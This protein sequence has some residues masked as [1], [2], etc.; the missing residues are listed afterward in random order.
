MHFLLR[1]L[2]SGIFCV[3][4]LFTIWMVLNVFFV[5]KIHAQ[6]FTETFGTTPD[7]TYTATTYNNYDT[8]YPKSGN[9]IISNN[10]TPASPAGGACIRLDFLPNTSA[11]P[12]FILFQNIDNRTGDGNISWWWFKGNAQSNGSGLDIEWST[13]NGATYTRIALGTNPLGNDVGW[14]YLTR[15]GI[16]AVNNLWLRISNTSGLS[17][18]Y[19]ML[20]NISLG[21]TLACPPSQLPIVGLSGR[22]DP[23]TVTL[24]A[25]GGVNY[26]WYTASTGGTP[27]ASGTIYTTPHLTN[28]TTYY[29]ASV[30]ADGCEAS[31]RR[32]AIAWVETYPSAPVVIDGSVCG[33]GKV[34][35]AA[36]GSPHNYRWYSASS[37]GSV[38]AEGSTF[39]TPSLSSTTTYY[40]SSVHGVCES[41]T[42]APVVAYVQ[43]NYT[44]PVETVGNGTAGTSIGSYTGWSSPFSMSGTGTINTS[45]TTW[46]TST[47]GST[48]I[49]MDPNHT[50]DGRVV[51]LAGNRTWELA[52][53]NTS[54]LS[55][56]QFYF[57]MRRTN[58]AVPV[59]ALTIEIYNNGTLA[60]V[61][62]PIELDFPGTTTHWLRYTTDAMDGQ[63]PS[64]SNLSIKFVNS[65]TSGVRYF[66]IDDFKI[67][68][69]P[70]AGPLATGASRPGPGSVSL[71]A[72]GASNYRWYSVPSAG[73][74]LATTANYTTPFLSSTTNYYVASATTGGCESERS[75]A[76]ATIGNGPIESPT[77]ADGHRCGTGTVT[78]TAT[79]SS[80][81]YRWY[82]ASSGGTL[83]ASTA[84]YTT[85]SI[86]STTTY[87]VCAVHNGSESPRVAV[88]ANVYATLAAPTEVSAGVC[89]GGTATLSASG[90]FGAY[91]W[92]DVAAGGTV[93]ATT[94]T[95][96]TPSLSAT[97]TYYVSSTLN[98]CESARTP[99][100]ATFR[101]G[102]LYPVE[103]AGTAAAT[104][105]TSYTGWTSGLTHSGTGNIVTTTVSSWQTNAAGATGAVAT[106]P[107][108]TISGR[109]VEITGGATGQTWQI[110][111]IN[112]TGFSNVRI[113]FNLRRNNNT[114]PLS[115]LKIDVLNN[116]N[117]IGSLTPTFVD[118][119]IASTS[120]IRYSATGIIPEG[121]NVGIR[122]TNLNTNG[123]RT[124][125]LDDFKITSSIPSAPSVNNAFRCGPGAV[126]LTASGAA[127]YRWYNVA[128]GGSSLSSAATY[129]T[130]SLSSTT[131]YFVT[132]ST[133]GGCEHVGPRV[134]AIASINSVPVISQIPAAGLLSN[135]SF[136]GNANDATGTNN[137]ILINGPATVADRFGNSGSAYSF[138]GT[139]Q[140]V[141]TNVTYNNPNNY[142]ISVWFRTTTNS[143]GKIIGFGS[144]PTGPS[145][146]WDRC[147]WMVNDGRVF[148]GVHHSGIV[149]SVNTTASYNDGNWH[150][151]TATLSTTTGIKFFIDGVY[152][153]GDATAVAGQNYTGYWRFGYDTQTWVP[154]PASAFFNGSLDD[155]L[156][157]DR[158]LAPAEVSVL[159]SSPNGAGS[160]SPVCTGGTLNLTSTTIT[161]A[162]Y[163]WTGPDGFTSSQQNPSISNMS[164]AKSGVYTVVVTKDGCS[165]T[166][167]TLVNGVVLSGGVVSADATVCSGL[168]SG[169][170]SLS[171]HTGT[172]IR[173][174]S[175]TDNFNT[176]ANISNTTTS[177]SYSNLTSTTQ[178][179][180]V[181][182]SGCYEASSAS[183]TITVNPSPGDPSQYGNGTWNIYGFHDLN[184]SNYAGYYTEPSLSFD[185]RNRWTNT[186]SPS[187][188]SGY[189]GCA[190]NADYFSVSAK[191]T[192]FTNGFYKIDIVGQEKE[193]E[194]FVNGNLVFS[195]VVGSVYYSNV[196]SGSL[197]SFSTIEIRW[198]DVN[199]AACYGSINVTPISSP[200][201]ISAGV[202]EAVQNICPGTTPA[203][204]TSGTVYSTI[205]DAFV[206]DGIYSDN[207]YGS[208]TRMEVKWTT[209]P[210]FTRYAYFTFDLL[211]QT[212]PVTSAILSFD[213]RVSSSPETL[214]LGLFDVDTNWTEGSITFNS[215]PAPGLR[216]DT[217]PIYYGSIYS[218]YYVDVS[219]HIAAKKAAGFNKISFFIGALNEITNVGFISTKENG[220][221]GPKLTVNGGY[222]PCYVTYQWQKSENCNG[223]WEN[224]S[225]A[226]A[227]SYSPAALSMTTCYRRIIADACSNTATS[228]SIQIN[229]SNPATPTG[230]GASR[231]G[232]GILTLSAS[233]S[234]GIYNWYDAATGGTLLSSD[235]N[236]TT[237]SISSTTTYYVAAVNGSCESPRTP[238][239]ATITNATV[240]GILSG[241]TTVCSGSN[242]GN[243][244]L[245]GH[246]GDVTVWESSVDNFATAGIAIPNTTTGYTYNNLTS[247][248]YYRAVVQ[249]A[250]CASEYSSVVTIA[251]NSIPNAPTTI[252][253]SRCGTGT[254]TLS[255]SGSSGTYNWYDVA[256][257]GSSLETAATFTT[258]SISA[259]TTYYVSKVES[260]C[261]G[262]RAEVIA[263]INEITGDPA[264]FGNNTW[265]VY[266]FNDLNY[267]DYRGYYTENSLSF[268]SRTRWAVAASPSSA[269]GYVGCDVNVDAFSVSAKRTGFSTGFYRVDI[270]GQQREGDLLINGQVISSNILSNTYF[271]NIW[272]GELTAA[273]TI[274]FRWKD[275]NSA[276]SFG[277]INIVPVSN[278]GS[279]YP[280]RIGANQ[281][282]CSGNASSVLLSGTV[283]STTDDAFVKGGVSANNNFGSDTRIWLKDQGPEDNWR[284]GYIMF[285]LSSISNP[286][287]SAILSIEARFTAP[288]SG[289]IGIYEVDT[290]WSENII[291]Y[292]SRPMPGVKVDSFPVFYGESYGTHYVDLTNYIEVKRLAGFKKLAFF[293]RNLQP[294]VEVVY[295]R[296][297]E[298]SDRGPKLFVN[299]AYSVCTINYQWQ[300]SV[301]CTGVW[302]NITGA[303]TAQ[304]NPGVLSDTVCY[305]RVVTDACG[306]SATSNTVQININNPIAP[307]TSGAP[308]CGSGS[309]TLTAGGSA[310]TYNWYNVSSGGSSL[311]NTSTYATPNIS[312]TTS[313]YVSKVEGG[314]EG[315]RSEVVATIN[316]IPNAPATTGN[317]RCGTGTVT[318]SASGSSGTYNWYDVAAG[319]SSLETAAAFTTPSISATTTYYVASVENGCEGARAE[320]VAAITNAT[321]GGTLS[322][323][324]TVCSGSNTGNITLAG[325]AGDV[326]GWESSLDNF[327][328]AGTAIANT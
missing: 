25:S 260:G 267:S 59:S 60:T 168:N 173:W 178:F 208:N 145:T 224:I 191:R 248:T 169:N 46:E 11:T 36:S 147:I 74:S 217:F 150:L 118:F 297:K 252:G 90:S 152:V 202:I 256:A 62:N 139:N 210:D 222:S 279:I 164:A 322:G 291:T 165:A 209:V 196:W 300:R 249:A 20:D 230:T 160:N 18:S 77:A 261:E 68:S 161:G 84:V 179:R 280:G 214:W 277:S 114:M 101:S 7:G 175:S 253:N 16:P 149:K 128:A 91:A 23:G 216:I 319:G 176:I 39:L 206:R 97:T 89:G 278:P 203:T 246:A 207:N 315:P 17:N 113:F 323:A 148:Y 31:S 309:V 225:G 30:N 154:A 229:V 105:I 104:T 37:G 328:T 258:P 158:E 49:P 79:G 3:T 308:R 238:V 282:I 132:A 43:P 293:L 283:L 324:T 143:G 28:T 136:N 243:I 110:S 314:C 231:C 273:S 144:Q 82:D 4:R 218:K 266:G 200:N 73:V 87:Y 21:G 167:Q 232:A 312:S 115:E 287:S 197:N 29:V 182:Q 171:G 51:E 236:Y 125:Q 122:F 119:D 123:A 189:S 131:T 106:D 271:Y 185:S 162:S 228:N 121:S 199:G 71:S 26:R 290:T 166:A 186:A 275:A 219:N 292:N 298:D 15:S 286:V 41:A 302:E 318:L 180:A 13:D 257:G 76:V 138:N 55:R 259:T 78:L 40:V 262:S 250:G 54:G 295:V 9:G 239:V 1:K 265:H 45:V 129:T 251:V 194:L 211:S 50:V 22:C 269:T 70:P 52:N 263:V 83:L 98:G 299:S 296:S 170:L 88:V 226:N 285:N 177:Q 58:T 227:P 102:F 198:K 241:A 172:I 306:N 307:V 75:P 195:D 130:P 215:R 103:T 53:V 24:T 72:S 264:V 247:T 107:N 100:I 205:K 8:E 142:T 56:I 270:V 81:S 204:I 153:G 120:W 325:H 133:P 201:S 35:L 32:A 235:A 108:N 61:L 38:I 237:P 240:G 317:S 184:Y 242:T 86:S 6:V 192:N 65:N 116:G 109:V 69:A 221:N 95:F 112:T 47:G 66:H 289:W 99:V 213:A 137:G 92:Y 80:G 313:Y 326:T 157:Y 288:A 244:T 57:N 190:I 188:A 220:G 93:L 276:S 48:T 294:L 193:C 126:N 155:I 111:G 33:R 5:C 284:Y 64:S 156:I 304:F 311:A 327:A 310:G 44:F 19:F 2:L 223:T 34:T 234:T 305:R 245:A 42:R 27:I 274:E 268:D 127:S 272:S 67:S 187:S 163:S 320:V 233:G 14:Y 63:I 281:E 316:T 117:V 10:N 301:K 181:V 174:E 134:E 255:A 303:N 135:Y 12:K 94:S 85:P 212:T 140:Y 151:A 141:T 124:W 254:V 146:N 96:A 183:A 321:V 159:Y